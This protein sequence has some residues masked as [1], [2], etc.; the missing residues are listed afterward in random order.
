MLAAFFGRTGSGPVQS[1]D[2][3][4]CLLTPQTLFEPETLL[5]SVL[6][7]YVGASVNDHVS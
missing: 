5:L 4:E 1:R 7:G 2:Y 6:I 3:I